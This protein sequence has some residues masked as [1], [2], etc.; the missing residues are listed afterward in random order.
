VSDNSAYRVVDEF[1][2]HGI[3]TAFHMLPYIVHTPNNYPGEMRE[4]HTF[5]IEPVVVEGKTSFSILK[6]NWTAVSKVE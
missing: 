3:G 1:T 5:T 6:D 2:G 4:G